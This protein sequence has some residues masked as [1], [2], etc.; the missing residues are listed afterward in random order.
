VDRKRFCGTKIPR[1][2]GGA[3]FAV[4]LIAVAPSE[5]G[6]SGASASGSGELK[7]TTDKLSSIKKE[8]AS[9]RKKLRQLE[10][11]EGSY[12][13]R[14]EAL[15]STIAASRKYLAMLSQRIESAE[16]IIVRL[17][18]SV[19]SA[20]SRLAGRQSIMKRR[21]RTAYLTGTSSPLMALF[22]AKSPIEVVH[23]VRYL[24]G[25]QRYDKELLV[26]IDQAK[27]GFNSKKAEFEQE[28]ARL[29]GLLAEKK[30]E[31]KLLVREEASRKELLKDV[32]TKKR[33]N[34]A[35]IA[36]LEATQRELNEVIKLLQRK[37]KEGP[38]KG[39]P[40]A[41]SAFAREKGRLPW[42]AEG[43]VTAR[44]GRVVHPLYQTITMNNGIDIRLQA[45]G[46]V[47]SVAKGSVIYTGSMRGLGKIV[48]V[49]HGADY[50]SI[51]A[52]LESI[53]STKGTAVAAGTSLG[54]IGDG[55][56]LHFEIRQAT[57]SFDPLFWLQK[58]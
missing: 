45:A 2:I 10:K 21:L 13:S 7:S 55:G 12:L 52:R 56:L 20:Q 16:T 47:R 28:R 17:N 11:A 49:G 29:A 54:S 44:F 19:T 39:P 26:T 46:K 24:E 41:A 36:E 3:L 37:K 18:D 6:K 25:I 15:E 22:M 40:A 27:T 51:Y 1:L 35:L 48:I 50:L 32:R 30:N 5:T 33:S 43:E 8:I 42:P 57:E 4:L 53:T 9:R 38:S 58:R 34:Q 14:L 23:R 31:Q